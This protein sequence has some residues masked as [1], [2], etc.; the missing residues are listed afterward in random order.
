[1]LS[2]N[3]RHFCRRHH[4]AGRSINFRILHAYPL[5]RNDA[6]RAHVAVCTHRHLPRLQH[7][8]FRSNRIRTGA[9]QRREKSLDADALAHRCRALPATRRR[10]HRWHVPQRIQN[11]FC[12][13]EFLSSRRCRQHHRTR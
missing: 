1:M 6:R 7:L 4:G 2:P 8:S 13:K 9:T 3:D 12:H 11:R 5:Q 10:D